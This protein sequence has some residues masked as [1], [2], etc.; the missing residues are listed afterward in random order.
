MNQSLRGLDSRVVEHEGESLQ[1][2]WTSIPKFYGDFSQEIFRKAAQ[3]AREKG[4]KEAVLTWVESPF[5]IFENGYCTLSLLTAEMYAGPDGMY[6]YDEALCDMSKDGE[7]YVEQPEKP[8]AEPHP[9]DFDGMELIED[10]M[11]GK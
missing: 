6:R 8:Q 5:Q 11:S 10:A 7:V 4:W 9:W 3:R 2:F 1:I